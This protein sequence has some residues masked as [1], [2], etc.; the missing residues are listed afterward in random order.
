MGTTRSRRRAGGGGSSGLRL[1]YEYDQPSMNNPLALTAGDL[2]G[3]A[4]AASLSSLKQVPRR[5][6]GVSLDA[7]GKPTVYS[8][9]FLMT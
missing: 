2:L 7:N 1:N 9:L 6:A 8:A 5:R 3:Q 4:S